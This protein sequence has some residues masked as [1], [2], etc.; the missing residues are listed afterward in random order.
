MYWHCDFCDNVIYKENKDNHLQSGFH[1]RLANSII[2]RYLITNT[3]SNKIDDT[4]RKYLKSHYE[5][6]ENLQVILSVKLLLPSNQIKNIRRQYPH[7]RDKLCLNQAFFL[8]KIKIIKE[9]LY[10]QILD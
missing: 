9:Q 7:D 10:S 4:I 1:K 3:K 6:Y 5:K 8:S 2:R